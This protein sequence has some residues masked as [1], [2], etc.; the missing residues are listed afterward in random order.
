MKRIWITAVFVVT[1]AVLATSPVLAAAHQDETCPVDECMGWPEALT[2]MITVAVRNM[3]LGILKTVA[4]MAWLLDK[5]A[6]FVFDLIVHGSI[7]D[8]LQEGVLSSLKSFMP[9]VLA[10]LLGGEDGLLYVA[11]M[12]AGITMT[13]PSLKNRLVDPGKAVLWAA[14]ILGVFGPG[15]MGYDLIGAVEGLRVGVME[16]II[17]AGGEGDVAEIVTGPMMAREADRDMAGNPLLHLPEPFEDEYFLDPQGYATVRTVFIEGPMGYDAVTDME[18]ETDDSLAK[19]KERA[20]PGVF[21]ALTSLVGGY[22]AFLFAL[23]FAL[24]MTGSLGLVIFLF[25]ALPM[26]LFEF[27]RTVVAGIF[28]KYL[29]I[30]ILSIGAA[31]FTGIVAMT[32]HVIPTTAATITDVLVQ[33]AILMPILGIEHMFVKWSFEAMMD[34]RNVFRRTMRAAFSGPSAPPGAL[35]RGAASTLRTLGSAAAFTI[36]GLGGIAASLA[37]NVAA[38][39]LSGGGGAGPQS[40]QPQPERGDVFQ[41]MQDM[42]NMGGSV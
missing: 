31:I 13:I 20:I 32:V 38:N 7:W 2:K 10:D 5:M 17:N 19:R 9:D 14:V 29:Q 12:V 27:G 1:A 36:P 4:Q 40:P 42:N 6:L 41:E 34:S 21:I 11:L 33:L 37:S 39:S 24:L 3:N 8:T 35:Q 18:I 16:R 28:D 30:V 25:A 15:A 23:I 22:A 26:G